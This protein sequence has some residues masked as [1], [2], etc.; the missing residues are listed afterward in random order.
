M[1]IFKSLIFQVFRG[2]T[3]SLAPIPGTPY[4]KRYSAPTKG[5]LHPTEQRSRI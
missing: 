5:W 2:V 4:T 3:P 1:R